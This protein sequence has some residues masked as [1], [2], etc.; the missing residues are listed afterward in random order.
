MSEPASSKTVVYAALLGNLLVA[1]TKF[2]AAFWSGSSAMLSE[3]VHSLVDTGNEILLIYGMYRAARPPDKQHPLGYGRELYFWSFIVALMIF[4]LGA[5]VSFFEGL[6]H[7]LEPAELVDPVVNYIVLGLAFLF[8]ASSW[9]VAFRRFERKR[10][11]H[12]YVEAATRSKDPT[13]F[14]VLLEDSAA[15]LGILI[16]LAGTFA[17]EK[18][19]QPLADGAASIAIALVLAATAAFLA[20]ESKGLLIGEPASERVR[21][22]LERIA[23]RQAGAGP[24]SNIITVHLAPDQIVAA[25]DLDFAD[26]LRAREVKSAVAK[27]EREVKRQLP[28]VIAL[29]IKPKSRARR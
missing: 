24:A 4:A 27:L 29:F 12:G 6:V 3:A 1:L 14:I 7:I 8:E 18:L 10:G 5:G 21:L 16:A 2:C 9:W 22:S 26:D 28:F 17:A 15:L 23:E 19:H 13:N 25:M 20:H 11:S